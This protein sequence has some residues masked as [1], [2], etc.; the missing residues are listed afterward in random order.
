MERVAAENERRRFVARRS[1][2]TRRIAGETI[3]VPIAAGVG[4]LDA[5][6]TL[7]DVG[8]TVWALLQQPV[9]MTEIVDAVFT[10]YEV[11]RETASNDIAEYLDLL[12]SKKLVEPAQEG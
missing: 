7:S 11:S 10:E 8:S 4:D 9:S 1:L 3:L 5:V 6:Y 12:L 2:V